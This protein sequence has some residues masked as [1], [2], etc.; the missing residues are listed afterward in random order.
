[1]IKTIIFFVAITIVLSY[2]NTAFGS[3]VYS[4]DKETL[5]CQMCITPEEL[6]FRNQNPYT[7]DR[8]G[9]QMTIQENEIP[10]SY[11]FTIYPTTVYNIENSITDCQ[12]CVSQKD[13]NIQLDKTETNTVL[14]I[15]LTTDKEIIETSDLIKDTKLPMEYKIEN[16]EIT[17]HGYSRNHYLFSELMNS[18]VSKAK[19]TFNSEDIKNYLD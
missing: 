5:E 11:S 9:I 7:V 10:L 16:D 8:I 17:F 4:G 3:A 6:E 13:Q 15:S 14:E 1:M 12:T 2:S 19:Q 18:E